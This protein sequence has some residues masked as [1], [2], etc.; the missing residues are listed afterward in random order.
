MNVGSTVSFK[1]YDTTLSG[2][3][4]EIKYIQSIVNPVKVLTTKETPKIV[5]TTV[6]EV[7]YLWHGSPDIWKTTDKTKFKE[8]QWQKHTKHSNKLYDK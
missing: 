5:L 7:T 3:I 8:V 1:R 6:Y 4:T 2:I